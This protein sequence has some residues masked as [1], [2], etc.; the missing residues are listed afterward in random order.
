MGYRGESQLADEVPSP[1]LLYRAGWL[2]LVD[3]VKV[4]IPRLRMFVKAKKGYPYEGWKLLKI[5]EQVRVNYYWAKVSAGNDHRKCILCAIS[6]PGKVQANGHRSKWSWALAASY[7]IQDRLRLQ[8]HISHST[9]NMLV[10]IPEPKPVDYENTD[11]RASEEMRSHVRKACSRC[12]AKMVKY[13]GRLPCIRCDRD[14]VVCRIE[15]G[16]LDKNLSRS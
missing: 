15:H 13:N 14:G 1:H 5:V 12:H 7:Q 9:T 2:A 4:R 8:G 16:L 11:A 6:W 10:T 3:D